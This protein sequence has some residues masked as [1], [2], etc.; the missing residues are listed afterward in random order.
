MVLFYCS[1]IL[2]NKLW[3]K[4]SLTLELRVK[5]CGFPQVGS[6]RL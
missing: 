1:E 4:F 6:F 2:G 5:E 3:G